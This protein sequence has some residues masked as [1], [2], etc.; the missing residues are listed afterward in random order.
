MSAEERLEWRHLWQLLG[1]G[2][3]IVDLLTDEYELR[4]V[5]GRLLVTSALESRMDVVGLITCCCSFSLEV[6]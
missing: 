2:G 3:E 6:S 1:L 4:F 5:D